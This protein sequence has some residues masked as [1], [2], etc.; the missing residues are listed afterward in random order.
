LQPTGL[1]DVDAVKIDFSDDG[2]EVMRLDAA[3]ESRSD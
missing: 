3:G 2:I 1:I